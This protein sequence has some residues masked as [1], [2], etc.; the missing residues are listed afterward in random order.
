MTIPES[1][2]NSNSDLIGMRLRSSSTSTSSEKKEQLKFSISESSP[3]LPDPVKKFYL[4]IYLK[5][6][7]FSLIVRKKQNRKNLLGVVQN[8]L[9]L[10]FI[11]KIFFDLA[12]IY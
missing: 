8:G 3:P 10:D 6:L 4:K 7:Y 2:N 5:F 1:S 11:F 12:Y 9:R